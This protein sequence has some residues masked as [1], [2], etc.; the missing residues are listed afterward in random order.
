MKTYTII[1]YNQ[2]GTW[3]ATSP[4]K[5]RSYAELHADRY[6]RRPDKDYCKGITFLEVNLPQFPDEKELGDYNFNEGE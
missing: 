6:F 1:L 3:S 4:F 2:Y 5:T